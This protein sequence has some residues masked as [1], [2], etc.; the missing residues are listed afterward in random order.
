[1]FLILY[2][3]TG[4]AFFAGRFLLQVFHH[5]PVLAVLFVPQAYFPAIVKMHL[6][7][8]VFRVFTCLHF[9]FK[10]SHDLVQA[11]HPGATA[12]QV[13][14]AHLVV[15]HPDGLV[16]QHGFVEHEPAHRQQHDHDG[17]VVPCHRQALVDHPAIHAK[18]HDGD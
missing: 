14:D 3:S 17:I 13:V 6:Q 11:I 1:M 16:F 7:F 5:P 8:P 10:P 15:A 12:Q 2:Q 4:I 18:D 9:I